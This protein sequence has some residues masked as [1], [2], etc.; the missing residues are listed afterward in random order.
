[1]SRKAWDYLVSFIVGVVLTGLSY[2][3]GAKYGWDKG[4]TN[5]LEV[6]AV[7]TS[8]VCT[9]LCVVERRWNYPLGAISSVAYFVLFWQ[10][11]L[12]SSAILNL[13]LVPTLVYG[14]VRWRKDV[15]TRPITHLQ[16][17]WLPLYVGITAAGW[18]VAVLISS[19]AKGALPWTDGLILAG[20]IMAQFLLDNKKLENWYIWFAIDAIA[21]WEYW[22]TGLQLVSIQY[23]FFLLNAVYGFIIWKRS[24]DGKG[25]RIDD[26]YAPH[27]G[28]LEAH[29]V[30]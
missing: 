19:A 27:Y 14:W 12:Y 17:K 6:F 4:N 29:P 25:V 23:V 13:Y 26:R 10:T 28:A 24:K 15:I 16:A 8:Y 9:Y 21:I 5:F 2:L 11:H 3:V 1:M 20:S 18:Y 22:V 30:R 7:F